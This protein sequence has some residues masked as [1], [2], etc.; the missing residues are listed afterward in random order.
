MAESKS[1][2]ADAGQ[3]EAQKIYDE[4]VKNGFLGTKPEGAIPNKEY[5]LQSGPSSPSPLE[6]HIAIHERRLADVKKSP[7]EEVK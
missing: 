5:T 7:A 3:S 2:R 1:A 6:E 4:A